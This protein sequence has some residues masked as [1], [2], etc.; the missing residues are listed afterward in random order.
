MNSRDDAGAVRPRLFRIADGALVALFA[1]SFVLLPWPLS[2]GSWFAAGLIAWLVAGIVWL[3]W[4]AVRLFAELFG[5]HQ[6]AKRQ[7]MESWIFPGWRSI[8]ATGLALAMAAAYLSIPEM[9]IGGA[10]EVI[11]I[12]IMAI[13]LVRVIVA[14]VVSRDRF[15]PKWRAWLAQPVLVLLLF[16]LAL[17]NAPSWAVF[18]AGRS[19]MEKTAKSIL[20]GSVDPE[21]IHRAGLYSVTASLYSV[22]DLRLGGSRV[23]FVFKTWSNYQP[24]LCYDPS[25]HGNWYGH[26]SVSEVYS[27]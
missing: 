13:W 26:W 17:T 15:R 14:T 4:L 21:S 11:L 2:P 24:E 19:S 8:T 18:L 10:G 6:A 12:V 25:S 16:V 22:P 5:K 23:C 20:D 1:V 3:I 7:G 9:G 27:D